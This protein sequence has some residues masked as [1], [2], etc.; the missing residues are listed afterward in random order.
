LV[1]H[2]SL[3]KWLPSVSVALRKFF[4][5]PVGWIMKL[6]AVSRQKM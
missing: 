1:W 3:I 5:S 6:P 4:P 2:I